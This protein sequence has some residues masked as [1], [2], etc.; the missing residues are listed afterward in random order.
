MVNFRPGP[1]RGKRVLKLEHDHDLHLWSAVPARHVRWED[2]NAIDGSIGVL[3]RFSGHA[4]LRLDYAAG[5]G[6]IAGADGEGQSAGLLV[7]PQSANT[8]P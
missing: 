4:C 3:A 5:D 2:S 1:V 6:H 8:C 7:N